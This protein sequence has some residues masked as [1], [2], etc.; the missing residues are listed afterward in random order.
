MS[1]PKI[2]GVCAQLRLQRK[3]GIHHYE[4]PR[5]NFDLNQLNYMLNLLEWVAK[6]V[7]PEQVETD[8][9]FLKAYSKGNSELSDIADRYE[10]AYIEK[11]V[12]KDRERELNDVLKELVTLRRYKAQNGKDEFYERQREQLWA[13]AEEIVDFEV[14]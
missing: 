6:V 7:F 9:K 3:E 14:E 11:E 5:F 8:C 4:N 12:T 2:R 10:H 1:I 13:R